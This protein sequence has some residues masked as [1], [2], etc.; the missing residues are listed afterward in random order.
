MATLNLE[1]DRL[2]DLYVGQHMTC[3][4]VS[5]VVGVPISTVRRRL[6]NAGA[7]RSG[8]EASAIAASKGRKSHGTGRHFTHSAETREKQRASRIK[9]ASTNAKGLSLK[10]NG[11]I[12]CTTGEHK[13]RGQ[14]RVIMEQRIGRPLLPGEVVHH[15]DGNRANN[16]IENLQLMTHAEHAS[17][18]AI[19]NHPKRERKE[20]GCFA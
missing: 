3:R 5:N 20:N 15:I 1:I 7:L 19:E 16:A 11:Y 9:W 10:P 2:I 12:E 8:R 6:M 17:H 18:H 14:H 13:F 4:E